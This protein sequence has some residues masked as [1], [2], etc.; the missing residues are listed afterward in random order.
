MDN[1]SLRNLL[2]DL[3]R[4]LTRLPYFLSF[5]NLIYFINILSNSIREDRIL[6]KY[7]LIFF[8]FIIEGISVLVTIS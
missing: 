7:W 4:D 1:K 3:S 2:Y 5:N 8:K 6:S